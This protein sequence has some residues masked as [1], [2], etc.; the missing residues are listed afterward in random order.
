MHAPVALARSSSIVTAAWPDDI[1]PLAGR[2]CSPAG[3]DCAPQVEALPTDSG[4]TLSVSAPCESYQPVE[5][6]YG[7]IVIPEEIGANGTVR[8]TLPVLPW[9][10]RAEVVGLSQPLAVAAPADLYPS[11][12]IWISGTERQPGLLPTVGFAV[13]GAVLPELGLF[14][15]DVT[16]DALDIPVTE[17]RCGMPMSF[18]LMRDGWRAPQTVTIDLP[19]CALTGAVIRL[20]LSAE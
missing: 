2:A 17:S 9:P 12:Y 18:T 8:V 13:L 4:W 1:R 7:H 11:G 3:A 6:H 19:D 10:A 16:P 14:A 5:I 20:P 15:A